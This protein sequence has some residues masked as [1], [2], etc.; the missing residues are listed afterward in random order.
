MSSLDAP[1]ALRPA[2][3]VMR[4][5]RLGAFHQTRVS[6]VRSL[7]RRMERENWTIER[8]VFDFDENGYGTLVYRVVTPDGPVSFVGFC[9]ALDADDRTDRVIAERWDTAF[10][11]HSG[12]LDADD[13]ERLRINTPLQEA[14][15]FGP[16]EIV[17]SRAN[18]S[19]RL[20]EHIVENLASGTQPDMARCLE[21]GYLMRTT[22]V[23]GN[24]KLGMAD[25]AHVFSSGVFRLPYQAEMLMVYLVREF[26][27]DLIE[28]VAQARNPQ[29]AVALSRDIKRVLGVGNATGLGMAPFL[30]SHPTLMSNWILARETALARVRSVDDADDDTRTN[31]MVLLER[32]INFTDQWRTDDAAQMGDI[33]VLRGE[34]RDVREATMQSAGFLPTHRPWDGLVRWAEAEGSL[35]LQEILNSVVIELYPDLVDSLEDIMG[36][37]ERTMSEPAMSLSELKVL[38]EDHYNWALSIDYTDSAAQHYFWYRSAEKE[39]PRFGER[40]NEPGARLET[41]IGVARDVS[42]LHEA[43]C[44]ACSEND[45]SVAEFLIAQPK[46][47]RITTRVQSLSGYPYAEIHDNLIGADCRP[48]DMLRCKLSIFGAGKFDPKSDRWTR[49]NFFQ[50]APLR[51]ELDDPDAL[52]WAFPVFD[53]GGA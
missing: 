1:I 17:L 14:G 20:F 34:L 16:G 39:E 9:N 37:D 24:G 41:P 5:S 31:F 7:I 53:V 38:I 10:A 19:M 48:I 4:L 12:E 46:W 3:Q 49:V 35:E 2:Q 15:R 44:A 26:S 32:V 8:P 40:F 43:V 36:S 29:K 6:F 47:R 42:A 22:A 28:H 18:K 25:L 13:L 52:D 50:G 30:I 21:I 23:Y 27:F 45:V 51:D 11:L 33:E